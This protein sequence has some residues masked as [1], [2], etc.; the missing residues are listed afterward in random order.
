MAGPDNRPFWT[1][2]KI[3]SSVGNAMELSNTDEGYQYSLTAQLVKNFSNGLS[4]LVAYT[5]TMAKDVTANPGSAA[6]SA[7]SSNT[8]VGSL[9]DPGLSYSNFATPHKIIGNVSYRFEY[10]N[11]FATTFSL[12]YQGYQTGRWSYTYSN[13]LNG[14]GNSSD[15]LYIPA[16]PTELTFGTSGG[17]TPQEQQDA[18]W[19]YVN[20][21][22]YLSEHK[23]EYAG[24]FGHIRP[25][26]HRFDAKIIQDI[27]SNFGTDHKYTIQLSVDF[28]NIGNFIN[29][30]WGAYSFNPL[31]NYDNVRP[32]TVVTKGNAAAAPVYRLNASSLDDFKN[33]S[34]VG[35]Y[36][37]ISS[38][39]GCLFGLRLIF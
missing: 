9:N 34:V 39:W 32:L 31:A 8:A 2:S 30:S 19:N 27:F 26:I 37:D 11:N 24:R 4:G 7:W 17:M 5:Y 36:A 35:K 28:L 29:D 1:T 12:V 20:N 3:V 33:K 15:L 16:S 6:A 38:T 13:D 18:F 21:N 25:W 22:E 10:L 23:G 14:D